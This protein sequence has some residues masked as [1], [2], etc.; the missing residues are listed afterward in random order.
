MNQGGK[1]LTGVVGSVKAEDGITHPKDK[2]FPLDLSVIL[3]QL[4]FPKCSFRL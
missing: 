1:T 2:D 3:D 4:L